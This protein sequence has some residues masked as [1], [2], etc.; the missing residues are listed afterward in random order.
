MQ[1]QAAL[2]PSAWPEPEH[3]T[4]FAA[5]VQTSNRAEPSYYIDDD[6]ILRHD[7]AN[8]A[9]YDLNKVPVDAFSGRR[10]RE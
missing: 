9:P 3:M 4:A 8:H 2:T 7:S 6:D 5:A 10:S 1:Y